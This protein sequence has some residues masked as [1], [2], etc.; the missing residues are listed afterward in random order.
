MDDAKRSQ[1]VDLIDKYYEEEG[2]R[3]T[4]IPGVHCL[5]MGKP[6]DRMPT[7]YQPSLC[8]IVQGKKRV[9]LGDEIL[10]YAPSEY[11][12]ASVDLPVIGE[13]TE[14][15]AS[16]PYMTVQI[17]LQP[18][19]LGE[20]L[21]NLPPHE[22]NNS[23]AMFV[24]KVDQDLADA[25]LRLL[26]LLDRPKDIAFMAPML[27]R[28]VHYRLLQGAEGRAV[29]QLAVKG[30]QLQRIAQ[31]IHTLK[32]DYH[33]PIRIEHLAAKAN[34]SVS[35][36]HAHFKA[37]TAMSPLQFQKKLRLMEARRLMLADAT[38]AADAAFR[39]GYESSSQFSRE[40]ARFFGM[41]PARDVERLRAA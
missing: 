11:L 37:V 27:M 1:I 20:L 25:A 38:T 30:S 23:R 3:P 22:S 16:K 40:Y 41:P 2:V 12:V 35:S 28:E 32:S 18:A 31:V 24:G 6:G 36:F 7:V 8:I 13:V 10:H 26:Q 15:S 17:D 9:L 4:V 19:L 21:A 33:Q 29:A 39:V 34:M 14:G 5:K